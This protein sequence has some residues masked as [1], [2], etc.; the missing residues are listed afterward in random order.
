MIKASSTHCTNEK[1]N[2]YATWGVVVPERGG[3][4]FQQISLVAGSALQ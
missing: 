2:R 1:T 3:A 4:P